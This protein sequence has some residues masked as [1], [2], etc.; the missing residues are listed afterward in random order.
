[1]RGT[2]IHDHWEVA[3]HP[4]IIADMLR[5]GGLPNSH[6]ANNRKHTQLST[7]IVQQEVDDPLFLDMSAE[8]LPF[9][10]DISG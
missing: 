3:T 1:M 10:E 4:L 9:N 2:G 7:A 8:H 5:K 6:A